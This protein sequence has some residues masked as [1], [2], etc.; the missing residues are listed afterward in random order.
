MTVPEWLPW[1][2]S[3]VALVVWRRIVQRSLRAGRFGVRRAAALYAAVIPFLVISAFALSGRLGPIAIVYAAIGFALS[4]T[5][6]LISFRR[7][8]LTEREREG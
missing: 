3:A 6:A 1:L 8:A 2:A 4:Y 5:L 7:I